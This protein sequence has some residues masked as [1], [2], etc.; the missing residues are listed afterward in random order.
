MS[1]VVEFAQSAG[2][3]LAGLIVRLGIV[4]L[5]AL[6]LLA[7]V[8]VA[9]G[10]VRLWRHARSAAR[11]LRRVGGVLYKP[12]PRYAAGH[13]WVERDGERLKVGLDGVAQELLPW[14]LAV[15][16]PRVGA[17]LREGEI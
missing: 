4:A 9:L 11:G 12:G 5:F 14:A 7:P 13:T 16:L 3:F 17:R 10:A 15:Q 1:G 2:A 8:A 6:A